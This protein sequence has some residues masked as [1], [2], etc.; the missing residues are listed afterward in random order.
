MKKYIFAGLFGC[1]IFLLPFAAHAQTDISNYSIEDSLPTNLRATAEGGTIH[2]TWDAPIYIPSGNNAYVILINTGDF[3]ES[4]TQYFLNNGTLYNTLPFATLDNPQ[5]YF[6][7]QLSGTYYMKVATGTCATAKDIGGYDNCK[8]STVNGFSS[9]ISVEVKNDSV[10]D[11]YKSF[12]P[13]TN[14]PAHSF[15]CIDEYRKF[16]L[17]KA[18]SDFA[19]LQGFSKKDDQ[20]VSDSEKSSDAVKKPQASVSIGKPDLTISV[21]KA[22]I[23]NRTVKGVTKKQ[24]KIG[25][26]VYN[27]SAGDANSSIYYRLNDKAPAL[28]SKTGIKAGKNKQIFIYVD[29]TEKGKQYTFTADPGNTVDE[30]NETNNTA[31]RV[32]GK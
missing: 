27:E 6:Y 3:N 8:F 24:Y 15:D 20:C 30:L 16:N 21:S 31:T 2:L 18:N 9:S 32:T 1:M 5:H 29:L 28:V 25:V 4:T 12:H 17:V 23:V 19:C 11:M 14:P 10:F 22:R 7:N 13:C 26:T